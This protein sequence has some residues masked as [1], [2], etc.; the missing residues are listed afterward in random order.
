MH[1]FCHNPLALAKSRQ[2]RSASHELNEWRRPAANDLAADQ[3]RAC[4][5]KEAWREAARRSWCSALAGYSQ[6]GREAQATRARNHATDLS[7][8]L[9]DLE[10]DGIKSWSGIARA[11]NDRRIPTARGGKKWTAN[12]GRSSGGT[13][14]GISLSSAQSVFLPLVEQ[15]STPIH[16][17]WG[18]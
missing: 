2:Y 3:G 9:R 1:R 11:F 10:R 18:F 6:A 15:F 14:H 17:M 5:S 13:T 16:T 8:I 4:G 12:T 7:P